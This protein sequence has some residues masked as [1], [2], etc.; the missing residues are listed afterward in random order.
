MNYV[1]SKVMQSGK[2]IFTVVYLSNIL[3]V[4]QT[5]VRRHIY[6]GRLKSKKICRIHLIK[7]SDI[8]IFLELYNYYS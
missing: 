7:R 2:K 4:D 3:G 6:K 5:T 1:E 8:L